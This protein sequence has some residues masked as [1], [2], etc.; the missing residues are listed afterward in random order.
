[1][2]SRVG[3]ASTICRVSA[4]TNRIPFGDCSKAARQASAG[5]PQ[6]PDVFRIRAQI[7]GE[8]TAMASAAAAA[9]N[10]VSIWFTPLR[11][12]CDAASLAKPGL[13]LRGAVHTF[14]QGQDKSRP[15][16]AWLWGRRPKRGC[17]QGCIAATQGVTVQLL[18]P[19]KGRQDKN[20]GE[21]SAHT[22]ADSGSNG[23]CG[24]DGHDGSACRSED[25]EAAPARS[26]LDGRYRQATGG[27][28]RSD[29]LP[30]RG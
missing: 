17:F 25:A 5:V 8:A 15:G 12:P 7:Q 19:Q 24:T 18:G 20:H 4:S 9:A 14:G 23:H 2:R 29:D 3:F 22:Q 10:A 6:T 28:C 16:Q 11:P 21:C 30:K 26:P 1:M 27:D 13:W